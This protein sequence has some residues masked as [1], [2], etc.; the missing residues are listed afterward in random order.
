MLGECLDVRGTIQIARTASHLLATG[1]MPGQAFK[2]AVEPVLARLAKLD[3]DGLPVDAE[4]ESIR[5]HTEYLTRHY[6]L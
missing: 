1:N 2:E 6:R 4:V 3:E 5:Q